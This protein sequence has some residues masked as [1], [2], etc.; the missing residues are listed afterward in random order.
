MKRLLIA[1]LSAAAMLAGGS[2]MLDRT[3]GT[4]AHAQEASAESKQIVEAAKARGEI[5]ERIDGY[6]APVG[7]ISP[8]V[9]AAMDDINISRKTKYESL[10]SSRGT[11]TRI[12]AQLAGEALIERAA[13]GEFVMGQSGQWTQK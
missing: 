13:P 4:V 5:G 1:G 10:A 2:L 3:G 9:R 8:D 6:L 11:T 7:A 12:V